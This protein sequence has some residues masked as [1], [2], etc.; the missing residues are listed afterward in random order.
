MP[1]RDL[2]GSLIVPISSSFVVTGRGAVAVG[3][4]ER[5]RLKKGA[6]IDVVGFGSVQKGT[7]ND[8]HVFNK[9]VPEVKG[10]IVIFASS[11]FLICYM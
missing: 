9:P 3:T 2:E 1:Q 5:G 11:L 7:V 8:L 10:R 4:L 6:S